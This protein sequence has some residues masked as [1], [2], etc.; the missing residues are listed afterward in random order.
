[1]FSSKLPDNER[2]IMVKAPYEFSS[3]VSAVMNLF[4]ELKQLV[5]TEK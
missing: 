4:E 5:P 3:S 1:M 2:F